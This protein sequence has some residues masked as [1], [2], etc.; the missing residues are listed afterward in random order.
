MGTGH[1]YPIG[2]KHSLRIAANYAQGGGE[3]I[4]VG[5]M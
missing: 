5:A 4:E 1:S 2:Q 3:K